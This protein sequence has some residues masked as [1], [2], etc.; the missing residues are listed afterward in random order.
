MK[1]K[2]FDK[3]ASL[4]HTIQNHKG[5]TKMGKQLFQWIWRLGNCLKVDD[6]FFWRHPKLSTSSSNNIVVLE[7]MNNIRYQDQLKSERAIF[8]YVD[9]SPSLS[10]D[11]E[12]IKVNSICIVNKTKYQIL[13]EWKS[14]WSKLW[15]NLPF[16]WK[17][18]MGNN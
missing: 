6:N 4:W 13:G 10:A 1:C 18:S 15:W 7:I 9:L 8:S 2:S 14:A 11:Q 16:Q 5:Y 12:Y 17:L 3:G